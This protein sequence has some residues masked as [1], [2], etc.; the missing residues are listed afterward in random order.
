M[1]LLDTLDGALMMSLYTSARLGKDTIAVL[2]YQSVLTGLTVVV[3]VVIGMI[4]MLS[5]VLNVAEPTG[6]FWDGVADAGDHYDIIGETL[7]PT[8]VGDFVKSEC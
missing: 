7:I 2:Y 3:A 6:A 8:A 5:L 4:Q 1:C